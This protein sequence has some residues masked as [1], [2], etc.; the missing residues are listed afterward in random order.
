MEPAEGKRKK[1]KKRKQ[2]G[3]SG[4]AAV[5]A[6]AAA[7]AAARVFKKW[8]GKLLGKLPAAELVHRPPRVTLLSEGVPGQAVRCS[9]S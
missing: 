7:A 8:L 1:S 3:K 2:S 5:A 6:A 4:A 9:V